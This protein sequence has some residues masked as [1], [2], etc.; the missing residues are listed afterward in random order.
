MET[1]DWYLSWCYS[2]KKMWFILYFDC[3]FNKGF[4]Q[5]WGLC[6]VSH[7]KGMSLW[8]GLL[9][10]MALSYF[11]YLLHL[12]LILG[13]GG[14]EGNEIFFMSNYQLSKFRNINFILSPSIK[15][16]SN[17]LLS[18]SRH[19]FWHVTSSLLKKIQKDQET[20]ISRTFHRSRH[21]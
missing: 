12:Q 15:L 18:V 10:A 16:H 2:R 8:P 1:N 21:E 7:L 11:P 6:V 17:L 13:G 4:A 3:C 14:R 5:V 19:N 9:F 20:H